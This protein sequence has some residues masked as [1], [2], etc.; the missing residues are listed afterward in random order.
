[1]DYAT[2]GISRICPDWLVG[3][4]SP[5]NF[6]FWEDNPLAPSSDLLK[7]YKNGLIDQWNY[8]IEY[9]RELNQRFHFKDDGGERLRSYVDDLKRRFFDYSSIVFLCYEKPDEFC[10]RHL[11]RDLFLYNN[12]KI[13]EIPVDKKEDKLRRETSESPSSNALF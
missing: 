8:S 4:K 12:I 3:T 10:H 7:K 11:L 5:S 6:Y 13:T 1:M 9:F 2:I